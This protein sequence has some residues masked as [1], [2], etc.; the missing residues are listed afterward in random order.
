[1][2]LR[3]SAHREADA[4][5]VADQGGRDGQQHAPCP[6]FRADSS[7]RERHQEE[8]GLHHLHIT[9]VWES[10]TSL[11]DDTAVIK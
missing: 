11:P 1:M 8:H 2:Q 5:L 7:H 10:A 4:L 6:G 9:V 3:V